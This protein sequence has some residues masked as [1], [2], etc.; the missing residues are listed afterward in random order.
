[1]DS[2]DG[3]PRIDKTASIPTGTKAV[4][5]VLGRREIPTVDE[6]HQLGPQLDTKTIGPR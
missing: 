5:A 3:F 4:S 2:M 1:M 6:N